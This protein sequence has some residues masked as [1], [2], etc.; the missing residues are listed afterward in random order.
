M[1]DIVSGCLSDWVVE[2]VGFG[3]CC[4]S[5]DSAMT[6]VLEEKGGGEDVS[7]YF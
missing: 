2:R 7:V 1:G 3:M 6:C 5:N 4:D